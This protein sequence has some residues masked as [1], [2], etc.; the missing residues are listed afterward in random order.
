MPGSA[1]SSQRTVKIVLLESF[2]GDRA[3]VGRRAENSLRVQAD[4]LNARGGLLGRH[5]EVVAAD[6]E[7]NAT[8]ARE[9]AREQLTDGQVQLVVGPGT[10]ATFDAVKPLLR[11]AQLPN[12]VTAAADATMAAAPFSFR[13]APSDRDRLASLISYL[14]RSHPD[15]RSIGLIDSGEQPARFGD[16][17]LAAQAGGSGLAYVGRA[18]PGPGDPDAAAAVQLLTSRGA[19][20]AF[21]SGPPE[22]AARAAAGVAAAGL[23]GR[24]QLLGL[25]GFG[26]YSFPATAGEAATGS[27]F[28]GG[29]QAYLTQQSEASWPAGYRDF[30]LRVSH[31]YGYGSNGVELQGDPAPADCVLQWSRAVEKAGTFTGTAVTSAWEQL[32]LPATETALGVRESASPGNHTTVPAEAVFVYSWVKSGTG[33]RLRQLAGPG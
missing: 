22:L 27:A 28:A 18:S 6:D 25:D 31:A 30:F 23:Q 9:L 15:V 2:S 33:Y 5:L 19:Q 7:S 8:K 10:S 13:A 4:L 11:Q 24:L 14:R 3:A 16:D 32:D 20:A 21:V 1:G 29:I 26:D 17:L 12:C